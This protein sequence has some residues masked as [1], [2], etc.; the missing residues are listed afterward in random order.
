MM[1]KIH[2]II[3]IFLISSCRNENIQ[4]IQNNAEQFYWRNKDYLMK[5]SNDTTRK[6]NLFFWHS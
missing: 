4:E 3:L 6:Y 5:L 1:N 2:L